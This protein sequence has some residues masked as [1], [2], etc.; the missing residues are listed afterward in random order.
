VTVSIED[1]VAAHLYL[2]RSRGPRSDWARG[3]R[4]PVRSGIRHRAIHAP[5]GSFMTTDPRG[6][7]EWLFGYRSVVVVAGKMTSNPG[8]RVKPHASPTRSLARLNE[9]YPSRTALLVSV[10]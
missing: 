6:R 5:R 8:A 10:A 3:E 1:T 9:E 2:E 4:H 7:G